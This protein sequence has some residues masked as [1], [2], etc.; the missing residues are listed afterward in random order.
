MLFR[1]GKTSLMGE[2]M[3]VLNIDYLNDWN[4]HLGD[5]N[6]EGVELRSQ[7]ERYIYLS[8]QLSTFGQQYIGRRT[9][10]LLSKI[11]QVSLY[12]SITRIT[13]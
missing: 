12:H 13:S 1:I 8:Q 10:H 6:D 11:R 4:S 3:A 5:G 2:M 7:T 9:R